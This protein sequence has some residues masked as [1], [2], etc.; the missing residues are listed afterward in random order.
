MRMSPPA[1]DTF[2]RVPV[3]AP[4]HLVALIF[5][6]GVPIALL[7][8]GDPFLDSIPRLLL[9]L[10]ATVVAGL[11]ACWTTHTRRIFVRKLVFAAGAAIGFLVSASVACFGILNFHAEIEDQSWGPMPGFE[12]LYILPATALALFCG[13]AVWYLFSVTE[14]ADPD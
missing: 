2:S 12:I 13:G 10:A 11:C 1:R 4:R 7:L 8:K 14:V 3:F 9:I 5:L 6:T